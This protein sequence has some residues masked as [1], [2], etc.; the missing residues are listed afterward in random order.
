MKCFSRT[1]S[2]SLWIMADWYSPATFCVVAGEL[3][4]SL[5]EWPAICKLGVK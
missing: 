4:Q 1:I 5:I 2:P 3:L